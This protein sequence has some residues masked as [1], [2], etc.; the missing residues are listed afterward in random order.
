MI[1]RLFRRRNELP[2][3]HQAENTECGLACL[4]MVSAFHGCRMDINSLRNLHSVSAAG[5]SVKHLLVAANKLKLSARPLKLDMQDLPKLA[6]PAVLHWDLDHF[7]VLKKLTA[8]KLTIHD[9][10][11]GIRH[12]NYSEVGIH[13]TGVAIE[14]T[15][16]KDFE[17]QELSRATR[18][19]ELFSIT[20]QFYRTSIQVFVLSL[21][22]QLLSL[23][24]PLY[25]QLA[26]DQG[27]AKQ[28]PDIILVIAMVFLA[29][30]VAKA[31]IS[32]LRGLLLIYFSNQLGFEMVSNVFSHLIKLP[33]SFFEKRE[34]GDIVS[35]F[36]SLEN[37]KQMVTQEMITIVVDGI[38]SITTLVILYLYSPML[39]TMAL[40]FIAVF[41]LV[42]VVSI[43]IEKN[44]RQEVLVADAKQNTN[45]M[46]NIRSITVTKNYG[47][48]QQR[49]QSWQNSYADTINAGYHLGH[50]QLGAGT[51][52]GLLFSI[53]HVATIYFGA[54]LV[55]ALELTIG[56]LMSFVFLKQHFVSSIAALLP[57]LAEIKLLKL[58]L[59]RISDITLCQSESVD[60]ESLISTTALSGPIE[61]RDLGFSYS[62]DSGPVLHN[63]NL[64]I[65]KGSCCVITGN[66]GS[67]KSTLLKIM[68]GLEKAND[69]NVLI[70]GK[71]LTTNSRHQLK[72]KLAAVL[73]NDGLLAGSLAYNI[74]LDQHTADQQRLLDACVQ[75]HI[76]E[77]INSLP[78]AF[79]TPVGDMGCCL[80][81]GQ[82]QRVLLARALYR[83]PSFLILD[84]ALSHLSHEMAEQILL[85][86]KQRGITVVLVTHNP[87]LIA[88]ADQHL[89]ITKTSEG[90]T[91]EGQCGV[92]AA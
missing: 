44:R 18:I 20:G 58:Q 91:I 92:L 61:L 56:Q 15:P 77:E 14:F 83:E 2:M 68:L 69:G 47:I 40:G 78:M 11:V 32:Y 41:V 63:I 33:V 71:T 64:T 52:Q 46:E 19:S 55:Y 38:F 74:H 54:Q 5:A 90:A 59:E 7:V 84:E 24:T 88:L 82:V 79:N 12:F 21:L 27:L 31:I 42:R 23:V 87:R 43:P 72:N 48:E 6:L 75:S 85:S 37:I 16:S 26:L 65:E 81:A 17:K 66:S 25:V 1:D 39:A 60:E 28:D 8:R 80:S 34:M 13:F 53:D 62:E 10:A 22:I 36:S 76:L 70:D 35:R 89:H 51:L 67:G 45:F 50:F 49:I 4:A 29:V 86:I 9:P 73:H 3:I 57:K 30:A